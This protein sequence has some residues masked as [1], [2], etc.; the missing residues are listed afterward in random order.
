VL[1]VGLVGYC[2]RINM[3]VAVI[4]MADELGWT[5]YQRSTA[6]TAFFFGYCSGQIPSALASTQL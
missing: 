6:M 3:S 2:D 1:L 5:L 4:G